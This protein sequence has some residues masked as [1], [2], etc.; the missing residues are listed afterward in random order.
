MLRFW[1]PSEEFTE[2]NVTVMESWGLFI[3]I[4]D[5]LIFETFIQ[6]KISNSLTVIMLE[7]TKLEVL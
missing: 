6:I 4:K 3:I 1:K 7:L 2:D 5:L